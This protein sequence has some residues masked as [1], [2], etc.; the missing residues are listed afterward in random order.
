MKK[1]FSTEETASVFY[2]VVITV[3][4]MLARLMFEF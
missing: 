3:C 4:L 2:G 1:V